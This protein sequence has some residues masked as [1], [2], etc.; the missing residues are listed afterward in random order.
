MS[1]Q[2]Q[3][4]LKKTVFILIVLFIVAFFAG[5]L[6]DTQFEFVIYLF[7]LVLFIGGFK[8]ISMTLKSK[9][10]V[11]SKVFL[12]LTGFALTIY[13]L[14]FVFAFTN[15][16]LFG[17]DLTEIMESLEDILYLDSL[18]LFIGVIGSIIMLRRKR[19]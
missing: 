1:E 18:L 10:T 2:N 9:V 17:S 5:F 12:L 11:M 13:F 14:F 7:Y 6:Q 3:R 16:I 15:N 8:L 4:R 19:K